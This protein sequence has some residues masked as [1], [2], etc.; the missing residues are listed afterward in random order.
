MHQED[1]TRLKRQTD[2]QQLQTQIEQEQQSLVRQLNQLIK[3]ITVDCTRS[4]VGRLK[5]LIQL[6]RSS[7]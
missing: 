4:S 7:K 1:I 3:N 6:A 5:Q 2:E